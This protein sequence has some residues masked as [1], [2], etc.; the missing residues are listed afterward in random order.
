VLVVMATAL[1]LAAAGCGGPSASPSVLGSAAASA[2]ASGQPISA[3][4][5]ARAE[6]AELVDRLEQIH[7]EPYHG[8][9]RDAWMASLDDLSQRL[10]QLTPLQAQVELQR[11]VALLSREGRDGHQFA[12]PLPDVE[13]PVLPIRVYE[14]ADGVFVTDALDPY[15]DLVGA[16][17]AAIGGHPIGE[18]LDAVEPLIPRDSPVTV[19][20]FRPVVLLRTSVLRGLGL[21][22]EGAVAV[23][24]TDSDGAS[25]EASLEP[26]PFA[27]WV[28]W[29]GP[30]GMVRL[31]ARAGTLYLSNLDERFWTRFLDDSGTL[32]VRYSMVGPA[33]SE[34]IAAM[35]DRAA[36]PD[37][38]R[39]VFD[40]RQNPGGDNTTYPSLLSA[41]RSPIIDRPGHF[42]VLTD[43]VTFSA[44]ANLATEL[45]QTTSAI[46]AGEPMGGGLNFWNDVDWVVLRDWPVPM[47]VGISTR[48][49][50]KA[51]PA[52]PRLTI[53]PDVPAP[54]LGAAYFADR[55]PALESVLA[56]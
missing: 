42:F 43:H 34:E 36:E 45:E 1:V 50:E 9:D 18:V 54:L 48:Y 27:D 24:V 25:R 3:V 51:E 15:G 26:V 16:R 13:G 12:L 29:A 37:V 22:E 33:P 11:L 17:L 5:A 53:E 44:A 32:Y 55:D 47:Q 52:D 35:L 7:P 49:W 41:L 14:F 6:L 56:R 38:V 40:L 30:L 46:F 19:S 20:D 10:P 28:A 39:V 23:T 8:I 21:V 2:S 4:D 31:P